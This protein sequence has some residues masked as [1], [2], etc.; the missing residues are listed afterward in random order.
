M[1]IKKAAPIDL[2]VIPSTNPKLFRPDNRD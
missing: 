1:I 2:L